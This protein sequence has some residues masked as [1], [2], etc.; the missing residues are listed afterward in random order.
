VKRPPALLRAHAGGSIFNI[1][2]V[3]APS[4]GRWVG[5]ALTLPNAWTNVSASFSVPDMAT[6]DAR[7]SNGHHGLGNVSGGCT[8]FAWDDGSSWKFAGAAPA[9]KINVHFAMHTHD[10]VCVLPRRR[11]S[12]WPRAARRLTCPAISARAPRAQG[13]GYDLSA[14]LRWHWYSEPQRH[15]DPAERG[16]WSAA[17]PQAQ[18]LLRRVS[19]GLRCL[20]RRGAAQRKATLRCLARRGAARRKATLRCLARRGAARRGS[21]T[22][23]SPSALYRIAGR[24]S[25]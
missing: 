17:G 18:I 13:L 8:S 19:D 24:P 16:G 6:V 25:L 1:T 4:A 3:G 20:A 21:L 5:V 10:D 7:F 11:R 2:W 9:G 12:G 23:P 15:K 22:R 14:L